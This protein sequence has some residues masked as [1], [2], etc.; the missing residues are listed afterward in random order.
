M[1]GQMFSYSSQ[2]VQEWTHCCTRLRLNVS[3]FFWVARRHTFTFVCLPIGVMRLCPELSTW[4]QNEMWRCLV[5][6]CSSVP[7]NHPVS[8]RA[9]IRLVWVQQTVSNVS[10][11]RLCAGK[12]VSILASSSDATRLSW[13]EP[14]LMVWP[15]LQHLSATFPWSAEKKEETL[16]HQFQQSCSP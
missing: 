7:S 10:R 4:W 13:L 5:P 9:E 6:M 1:S 3:V 16:V 15:K 14:S 11:P 2:P 8:L 12:H